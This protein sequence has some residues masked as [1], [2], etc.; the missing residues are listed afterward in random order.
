[1]GISAKK[2][3]RMSQ[4]PGPREQTKIIIFL[5][6]F[7][8]NL[9]QKAERNFHFFPNFFHSERVEIMTA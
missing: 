9:S 8:P 5:K 4:T 6:G 7:F 1:M 3:Q 2:Q